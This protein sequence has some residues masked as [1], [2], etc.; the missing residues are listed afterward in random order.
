MNIEAKLREDIWKAIQA[1]YEREDY[2]EA[3][4]DAMFHICELLREKSGLA[5]KDGTKLV[6]AALMGTSPAILIN[7]YSRA[8]LPQCK[9]HYY[10]SELLSSL[11]KAAKDD[12]NRAVS[13]SLMK[14]NDLLGNSYEQKAILIFRDYTLV[15]CNNDIPKYLSCAD[16]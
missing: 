9:L 15:E 11:S 14:C 2:T 12:F 3:V 10:I 16:F 8:G 5:D 7:K 1:H 6:E 4:R 13:K